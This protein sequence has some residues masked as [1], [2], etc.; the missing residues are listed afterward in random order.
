MHEQHT[1]LWHRVTYSSVKGNRFC[2]TGLPGAS[3]LFCLI[4]NRRQGYRMRRGCSSSVMELR[5]THALHTH[6]PHTCTPLTVSLLHHRKERT[7]YNVHPALD[8]LYNNHIRAFP[9]AEAHQVDYTM[10]A[11]ITMPP[12]VSSDEK[13]SIHRADS[14]DSDG[15]YGCRDGN[16]MMRY[17]P[18]NVPW[19]PRFGEESVGSLNMDSFEKSE[20]EAYAWHD[21][22]DLSYDGNVS[23]SDRQWSYSALGDQ[24]YNSVPWTSY[25]FPLAHV[26][27]GSLASVAALD[28]GNYIEPMSAQHCPTTFDMNHSIATLNWPCTSHTVVSAIAFTAATTTIHHLNRHHKY[29]DCCL[30]AGITLGIGIGLSACRDLEG[31]LLK[32]LPWGILVGLLCSMVLHRVL[33]RNDVGNHDPGAK[34]E[35]RSC[36]DGAVQ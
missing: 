29:Q 17:D 6:V 9:S 34:F 30:F 25:I 12:L 32:A 2:L 19:D 1:R 28:V 33:Q 20:P 3:S 23:A 5:L 36:H 4:L 27:L 16:T 21:H 14:S 26:A 7:L 24:A 22:L 18:L 35:H 8:Y 10:P 11:T 13:L 31:A 15:V